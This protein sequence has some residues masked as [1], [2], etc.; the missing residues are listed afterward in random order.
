MHFLRTQLGRRPW[1]LFEQPRCAKAAALLLLCLALSSAGTDIAQASCGDYLVT[2]SPS[3]TMNAD[4]A[5]L[6]IRA[7]TTHV[8]DS[9][10]DH[11]RPQVPCN[12]PSCNR[13]PQLPDSPAPP[14]VVQNGGE[15]FGLTSNVGHPLPLSCSERL[16][17]NAP[18]LQH[19]FRQRIE[20]PPRVL[21]TVL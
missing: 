6:P 13:S 10:A 17:P 20:R 18:L 5:L 7:I 2:H 9:L 15:Q 14:P 16:N 1:R 8:I 4:H 12:G 19:G 11:E 3:E 21:P